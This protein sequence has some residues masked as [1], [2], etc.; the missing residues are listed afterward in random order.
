[1][2]QIPQLATG[3]I[4]DSSIIA[5]IGEKGREAV[6]PLENNTE[7]MDMLVEKMNSLNGGSGSTATIILEV[8]RR[9]F[10]R[11]VVDLGDTERTRM[12]VRIQPKAVL[13]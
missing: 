5:N 8:D 2:P 7:W 4:V 13:T 1:V 3:G 9:E 6:L 12:G 11:A 10:G